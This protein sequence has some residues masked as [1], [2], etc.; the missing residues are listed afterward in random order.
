MSQDSL[1]IRSRPNE[2]GGLRPNNAML[3]LRVF[4]H[5]QPPLAKLADLLAKMVCLF[6]GPSW[7]EPASRNRAT[8][9]MLSPHNRLRWTEHK[10]LSTMQSCLTFVRNE[11]PWSGCFENVPHMSHKCAGERSGLQYCVDELE[12]MAYNVAVFEGDIQH[13]HAEVFRRRLQ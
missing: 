2:W 12:K 8:S 9:L 6:W 10:A 13:W 3:S 1:A 11:L 7:K 4:V 5:Q